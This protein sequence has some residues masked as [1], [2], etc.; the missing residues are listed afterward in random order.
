MLSPVWKMSDGSARNA[1]TV[2]KSCG[3][4]H[5]RTGVRWTV[6]FT[7]FSC[8][9]AS[10]SSSVSV[11]PEEAVAPHLVPGQLDGEGAHYR[12]QRRLAGGVVLLAGS[13]VDRAGRRHADQRPALPLLN[14]HA[15]RLPQAE[16][17]AVQV[18]PQDAMPF[19]ERH[20]HERLLARRP[21]VGHQAIEAAEPIERLSHGA[22]DVDLVAD[23]ALDA[24]RRGAQPLQLGDRLGIA[25]LHATRWR[26][27][28]R[29]ERRRGRCRVRCRCCRP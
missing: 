24:D 15:G 17:S 28:R 4:A 20:L 10:A 3:V 27:T 8:V 2:S 19:V 11:Q 13:P 9:F 18:D 25:L 21:G 14:Q 23:I 26:R 6:A 5:R 29:P 7:N 16:E 1:P 12:E 22:D